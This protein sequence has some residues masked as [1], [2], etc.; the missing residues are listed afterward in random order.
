N[1]NNIE[2]KQMVIADRQSIQKFLEQMALN[3]EIQILN[4]E[5]IKIGIEKFVIKW[6]SIVISFVIFIYFLRYIIP[7]VLPGLK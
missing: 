4:P 3:P 6:V 7:V 5:N 2:L 1:K